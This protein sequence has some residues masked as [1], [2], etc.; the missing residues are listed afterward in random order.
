M[1]TCQCIFVEQRIGPG[2]VGVRH[3][4]RDVFVGSNQHVILPVQL[5]C[6][7]S[8]CLDVILLQKKNL[9]KAP[10]LS[11]C[12]L[13]IRKVSGFVSKAAG[14]GRGGS[15]LGCEP[16]TKARQTVTRARMSPQDRHRMRIW[17]LESASGQTHV[18]FSTNTRFRLV[19][20][21]KSADNRDYGEYVCMTEQPTPVA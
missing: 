5:A 18:T 13:F 9:R 17:T 2:A 12:S 16:W 19:S 1:C 15:S 10:D 11:T 4:R 6:A 21:S 14:L 7:V 3:S 8:R 20:A